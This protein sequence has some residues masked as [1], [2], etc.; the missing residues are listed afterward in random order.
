MMW[1]RISKVTGPLCPETNE[2][3]WEWEQWVEL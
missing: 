2:P 3:I 1:K